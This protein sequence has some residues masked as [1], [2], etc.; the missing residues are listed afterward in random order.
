M[1]EVAKSYLIAEKTIRTGFYWLIGG[2]LITLGTYA[3][4]SPGESYFIF[5]GP[6]AYGAYRIY[7]GYRLKFL[8][9]KI[10]REKETFER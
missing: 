10:I 7:K 9:D 3:S 6:A 2:G 4:A 8:L 1:N 5:W